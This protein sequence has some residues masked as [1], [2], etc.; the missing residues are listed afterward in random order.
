[1]R[2]IIPRTVC[3]SESATESRSAISHTLHDVLE[4]RNP[5]QSKNRRRRPKQTLA[6][7]LSGVQCIISI[8]E[9]EGTKLVSEHASTVYAVRRIKSKTKQILPTVLPT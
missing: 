1:M 9:S 4:K 2:R 8:K 3:T 5:Y 7:L 6:S